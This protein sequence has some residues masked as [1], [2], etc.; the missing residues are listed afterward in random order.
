MQRLEHPGEGLRGA[1]RACASGVQRRMQ[2]AGNLAGCPFRP[3]L[4]VGIAHDLPIAGIPHEQEALP[5]APLGDVVLD[6]RFHTR[7]GQRTRQRIDR[8][9]HFRLGKQ[10][11][12]TDSILRCG[13]TRLPKPLSRPHGCT[14]LLDMFRRGRISGDRN[15]LR[16]GLIL[17]AP[18]RTGNPSRH[19]KT[20]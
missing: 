20:D 16:H 6:E 9:I 7:L 4:D 2:P 1:L 12:E 17:R 5:A 15:A 11:V 14:D 3:D 10:G 8:R 13:K 19:V 18:P